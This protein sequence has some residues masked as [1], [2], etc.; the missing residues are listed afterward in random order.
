M[1]TMWDVKLACFVKVKF[2][3]RRPGWR[4]LHVMDEMIPMYWLYAINSEVVI[5]LYYIDKELKF[6]T[7]CETVFRDVP[8]I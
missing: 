7:G 6:N 3:S 8:S 4:K 2:N 5:V 1:F